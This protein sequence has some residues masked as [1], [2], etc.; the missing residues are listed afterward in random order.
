MTYELMM[1]ILTLM[2]S[3]MVIYAITDLWIDEI[4]YR[5]EKKERRKKEEFK[6]KFFI[7]TT[8]K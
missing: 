1:L 3:F 4:K 8:L 6:Q 7:Q 2:V 5:K